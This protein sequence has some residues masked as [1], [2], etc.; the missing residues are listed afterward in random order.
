MVSPDVVRSD[1]PRRHTRH[2]L[3]PRFV[4]PGREWARSSPRPERGGGVTLATPRTPSWTSRSARR[5]ELRHGLPVVGRREHGGVVVTVKR[6][7]LTV[8]DR[9][10]VHPL[11]VFRD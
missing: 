7:A 10:D 9:P 6:S 5:R 2:L 8:A 4:R 3:Y 1:V 11:G